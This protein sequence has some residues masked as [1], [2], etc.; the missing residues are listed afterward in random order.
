MHFKIRRFYPNGEALMANQGLAQQGNL[1][2]PNDTFYLLLR[3][4]WPK[5]EQPS[6]LPAGEGTWQ[7]PGVM[8]AK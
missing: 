3:L 1:P 2:A 6:V 7:P 5:T 8:V 4:Y